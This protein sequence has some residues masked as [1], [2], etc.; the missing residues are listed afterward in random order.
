MQAFA[1]FFVAALCYTAYFWTAKKFCKAYLDILP[2]CENLFIGILF[3]GWALQSVMIKYWHVSDIFFAMLGHILFMGLVVLLFQGTIEKK[4]LAASM[5]MTVT[6]MVENFCSACLSC[7]ALIWMHVR[8][9]IPV[10]FLGEWEIRLIAGSSLFMGILAVCWLSNHPV[11]AFCGKTK[12]W[13]IVL[14]I[15]FLMITTVIGVA[16]LGAEHGILVRSGGDMGL[17]YDQ[18]FSHIGFCVLTL[19]SMFAIGLYVFGME[20]IYKE[21][22]KSSQYYAQVAT[23]KMLEEQ[24]KQMERLRHDMKNHI[25]AL[26]G[27]LENKELDKMRSYLG[28]MEDSGGYGACEETTGNKVVDALLDQKRKAAEEKNILWECDVQVPKM[29]C[30]NEFDLCVLFGN[31]LDNALEAC[32]RLKR[33]EIADGACGFIKI[34]A[35]GV[36]RC[37][38]MEVQ[39]STCTM[40]Q[41]KSDFINKEDSKK[42][43]IGLLNIKDVVRRYNGVM[44]INHQNDIFMVSILIPLNDAV[45]DSKQA[46]YN[47][48]LI[49]NFYTVDKVVKN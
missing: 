43:G 29:C 38:L 37:F 22:R 4:I 16:N 48:E 44:S 14:A 5:L 25:I 23:Y 36:K 13:H 18:I 9:D 35:G 8:K 1:E 45:H 46:V 27:L 47:M 10:P 40:E 49:K 32:E 17:Y 39:N 21:Q 19:L 11:S 15:P 24:Y 20:K 30:I 33:D 26:S 7:V 31:L 6:V 41:N 34:Q 42:H 12:K 2:V 3:A 28:S